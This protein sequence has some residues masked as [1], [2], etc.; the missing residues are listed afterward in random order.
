[1]AREL[2]SPDLKCARLGT[3][4][5]EILDLVAQVEAASVAF[6]QCLEETGEG[7]SGPGENLG[8]AL[9]ALIEEADD[10]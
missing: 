3:S 8:N 9:S 6:A 5:P 1:L 2:K 4:R 7:C 10:T